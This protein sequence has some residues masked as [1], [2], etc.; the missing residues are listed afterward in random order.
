MSAS[1]EANIDAFYLMGIR[2][3][4]QRSTPEFYTFLIEQ[5][6]KL[7]PLISNGRVILFCN[8][9]QAEEALA[10]AGIHTKLKSFSDERNLYLLDI[11]G[12]LY[13]L[14]QENQDHN[15]KIV[16]LLDYLA[17]TLTALGIPLP[18]TFQI[19][20]ELGEHLDQNPYFADF[21]S[22]KP[23]QREQAIDGIRWC[24]GTLFSLS[25]I[26]FPS[27]NTPTLASQSEQEPSI[28]K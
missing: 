26:L 4:S 6:N 15:Q 20:S 16:N 19:L 28:I 18:P 3:N 27:E 22:K 12:A 23:F 13:L 17:R 25:L 2:V 1:T 5:Q 11:A 14:N 9:M 7:R 24:I 10:K 21:L 8:S